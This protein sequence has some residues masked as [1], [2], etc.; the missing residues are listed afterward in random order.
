[1]QR[2][3][4]VTFLG[5]ALAGPATAQAP[6]VQQM[7][8]GLTTGNEGQDQALRDAF[9]RG[10]RRGRQDEARQQSSDRS[11]RRGADGS[12]SS[13]Y[14]NDHGADQPYERK[15]GSSGR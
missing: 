11:S 4:M 1:M 10:Y 2:I 8:Q 12:N 13:D 15:S 5:L 14:Q 3:I 9:E 6:N 7:L